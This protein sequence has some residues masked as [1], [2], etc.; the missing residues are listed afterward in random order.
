[1][2]TAERIKELE[3]EL[4]KTKYN[5]ATQH[6]VGL[7]KAKLAKLKDDVIRKASGGKKGEGFVVRKTGDASV[8][9]LGFPSVGKSTLLNK[10]T[11]TDSPIGAY[12]FTTLTCIPGVLEYK[13]AKIQILDVP[14]IVSGAASGRGRGKEVLSAIRSANMVIILVDALQ[15]RHCKAVN[16]EAREAGLRLN[17]DKPDVK[18]KKKAK[19]GVQVGLTVPLTKTKVE[20]IEGICREM[21]IINADVVIRSDLDDD[22]MIDVID[23][24]KVYLPA[25]TVVNKSDLISPAQKRK[26]KKDLGVD[27]FVSAH[28]EE[29]MEELKEL[30]FESLQFVRIYMKEARKKADMEEPLIMR[31]GCTIK[32][33]CLKLHRDFLKKFRYARIWGPSAKFDGQLVRKVSRVLE[34]K[35][36]LEIHLN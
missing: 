7:V 19:G 12:A 31:R 13:H 20:T 18:I 2:G 26:M 16:K 1:M 23:G 9:L 27:L 36:V 8:V 3:A 22:E 33:I 4:K 10:L 21:G 5:K 15:P 11:G 30:I 6:H 34:D 17:Q 25:V 29:G 14:G 28:K 32:D 24:N 35:D